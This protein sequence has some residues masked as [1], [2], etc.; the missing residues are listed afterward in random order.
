MSSGKSV[1]VRKPAEARERELRLAIIRIHKGRTETQAT[2]VTFASVA[3]EAGVSPALIHNCYPAVADLIRKLQGRTPR[4]QR[5]VKHA[6]LKAERERARALRADNESLRAKVAALASINEMLL[7]ENRE[8]KARLQ[9][10]KVIGIGRHT[11][12]TGT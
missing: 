2:K 12:T 8:L 6:A 9:H 10:S 4:E 3:R 5:D 7:T 11:P 1:P